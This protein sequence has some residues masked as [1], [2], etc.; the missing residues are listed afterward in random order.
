V[1]LSIDLRGVLA[2]A[3]PLLHREL[4]HTGYLNDGAGY[5]S[6][7]LACIAIVA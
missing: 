4:Q 1:S 5:S 6:R 2:K 3:T 7:I